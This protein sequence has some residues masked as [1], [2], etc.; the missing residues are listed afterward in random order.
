MRRVLDRIPFRAKGTGP[1]QMPAFAGPLCLGLSRW[2]GTPGLPEAVALAL[3][4]ADRLTGAIALIGT[5][6]A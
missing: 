6:P 5:V 4:L 1:T 3:L 2:L